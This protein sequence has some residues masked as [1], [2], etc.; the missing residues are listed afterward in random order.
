[1]NNILKNKKI[2][3]KGVALAEAIV[4]VFVLSI[5]L[6]VL[7]SANNLYIK[8]ADLNMLSAQAAFLSEEGIEATHTIIDRSWESFSV[9]STST[10]YYLYFSTTS[11]SWGVVTSTSSA[12]QTGIFTRRINIYPVSRDVDH[13][14]V[15][16][17]GTN[18][19][20]TR[21]VV[22]EISWSDKGQ[23]KTKSLTIYFTNLEN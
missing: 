19:D 7:I 2:N 1:M 8:S 15:T 6:M 17:G 9:L 23:S 18:D 4:S 14:I 12:T 10:P 3:K 21:R 22:S 5:I 20:N 11:S 16:S 13:K